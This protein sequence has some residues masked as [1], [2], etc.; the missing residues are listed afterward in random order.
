MF[1][2]LKKIF[3]QSSPETSMHIGERPKTNANADKNKKIV[4]K[5][6]LPDVKSIKKMDETNIAAIRNK[7]EFIPDKSLT[8][9][10]LEKNITTRVVSKKYDASDKLAEERSKEKAFMLAGEGTAP[11]SRGK[12]FKEIL[13]QQISTLQHKID[14]AKGIELDNTDEESSDDDWII[15]GDE[16]LNPDNQYKI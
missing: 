15:R 13:D 10:T 2:G 12:G 11:T 9:D 16:Q 6:K 7:I 3:G 5:R 14:S 1:K 4:E 8:D